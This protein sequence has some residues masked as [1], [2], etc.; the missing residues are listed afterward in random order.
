MSDQDFGRTPPSD[1]AA[2]QVSLGG[3]LLDADVIPDVLAVLRPRDYFRPAH[4]LISEVVFALHEAG[5]PAGAVAV[6]A[7]LTKR[8]EIA[9]VGGAPYLHTLIAAVPAAVNAGY[10]ARIV[11]GHAVRRRLIEAGTRIVQLGYSADA[12]A[13]EIAARALGEIED[14]AAT[15]S[16]HAIR[17]IRDVVYAALH[18]AE[19]GTEHGVSL[20]WAD[21]DELLNGV[22]PGQLIY[23]AARPAIGKSLMGAGIAAHVALDLG[24]PALLVSMEMRAEDITLRLISAQA[25]VSLWALT[26]QQATQ[27]DWERVVKVAEP[28]AASPLA[29]DYDPW[30]SLVSI[31]SRLRE[32]QRDGEPARVLV[33]DYLG[34]MEPPAAE[35]RQNAVAALSRGLKRIAGEFMIP[36]IALAQLNR[37]P[38]LR[39]DH[40]PLLADLRESGAQEQDADVVILLHREDAYDRESPRAGEIDLIVAKNRTGPMATITAAFQGHYGRIKDMARITE[41]EQHYGPD[42]EW[43]PSGALEQEA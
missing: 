12:E 1:L 37:G 9:R 40:R 10:Y 2:E 19:H 6:C 32:M 35:N 41:T 39:A 29:V 22:S 42:R 14:A 5:E 33:V 20:P 23:V 4:Q 8:G 28:I 17:P 43:S 16:R 11:A 13:A 25:K 38:E 3:M 26:H 31:R 30:C 15:V 24:L 18:E 34:L 36:V 21:L 7:E 27:D